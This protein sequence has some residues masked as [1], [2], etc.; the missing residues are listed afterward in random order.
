LK[1]ANVDFFLE[2]LEKVQITEWNRPFEQLIPIEFRIHE[3]NKVIDR[4]VNLVYMGILMF[5]AYAIF[6]SS[7][8]NIKGASKGG[9]DIFSMGKSAAKQFEQ[10]SKVRFKDVAGLD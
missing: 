9:N 1:I 8:A 2:T 4:G 3:N 10:E 7:G 6:K 5:I